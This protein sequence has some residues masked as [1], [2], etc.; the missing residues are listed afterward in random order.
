M[1]PPIAPQ[2][3]IRQSAEALEAAFLADMFKAAHL[4]APQDALGGGHG[5]E[6]FASFMADIQARAMVARGGLGLAD[7]IAEA[8]ERRQAGGGA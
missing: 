2:P 1:I 5:E 3:T 6:Q 4:F 8:L 7:R